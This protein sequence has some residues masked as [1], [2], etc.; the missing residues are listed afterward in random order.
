MVKIS[1][2]AGMIIFY[3]MSLSIIIAFK[4]KKYD[5]IRRKEDRR[6]DKNHFGGFTGIRFNFSIPIIIKEKANNSELNKI[7]KQ[8]NLLTRIFWISVII[9]VPLF[10]WIC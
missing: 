9:S 6:Y 7:I 3:L 2:I 5:L 10:F 4:G 1:G 8:Y